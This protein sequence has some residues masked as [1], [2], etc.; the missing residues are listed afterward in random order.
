MYWVHKVSN[1]DTIELLPDIVDTPIWPDL[2]VLKAP[3]VV[4]LVGCLY[5]AVQKRE[6]YYQENTPCAFGDPRF[7]FYAGI[8]HGILLAGEISEENKGN[9]ID[10]RRCCKTILRVDK[11]QKPKAYY[12]T[13]KENKELMAHFR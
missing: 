7:E 12:E 6:N 4:K 13:V 5:D 8:V 11:V 10:F 2:D 1:S 3:K 9:Y